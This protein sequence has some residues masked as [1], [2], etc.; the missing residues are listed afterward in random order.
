MLLNAVTRYESVRLS[1]DLIEKDIPPNNRKK[2]IPGVHL[3][4]YFRGS[5]CEIGL[6]G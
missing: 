5:G 2:D 4:L 3:C 1:D 6:K